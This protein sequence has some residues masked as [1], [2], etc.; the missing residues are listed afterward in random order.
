MADEIAAPDAPPADAAPD[1]TDT[2]APK[3]ERDKLAERVGELTYR[4]KQ[5][6]AMLSKQAEP[7]PEAKPELVKPT[8]ESSGYDEA[9][10][11]AAMDKYR[12]DLIERRVEEG[13]SRALAER[14]AKSKATEIDNSFSGR[15]N[16]LSKEE[17]DLAMT[18]KVTD[19]TAKLIKKSDVGIELLQHL[20]ANEE[21]AETIAQL[22]P[23]EQAMEI[24]VLAATLR[25]PKQADP[26]PDADPAPKPVVSKAPP[27]ASKLDA[28]NGNIPVDVTSPESD[29]L[30]D[31][32]W[33][34]RR[35]K[36][37]S[38]RG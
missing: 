19:V 3:P 7:K 4:N 16:K 17:R 30:S 2:P 11:A 33:T 15:L 38:R 8:L 12:D 21:L 34:K 37:V 1:V 25:K 36:Q 14:E 26:A 10:H 32:E 9:A 13:V 20:A 27:P 28:S 35:N 24:G 29:K 31:A 5:L 23:E 18:A 22:P 6:E